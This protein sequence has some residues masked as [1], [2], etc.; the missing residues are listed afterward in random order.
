MTSFAFD[1]IPAQTDRVAIVTGANTGIGI[2]T[3]RMLARKGARVVLACR[4]PEKGQRAAASIRAEKPAGA[5]TFAELDLAA[6]LCAPEALSVSTL[7]A[8]HAGESGSG[9]IR[10]SE[11]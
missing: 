6:G 10:G 2:E 5:A 8:A 4:S 3:A 7:G 9:A 11:Q 1:D